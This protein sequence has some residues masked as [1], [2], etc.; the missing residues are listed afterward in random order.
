MP[1]STS[2]Q[3]SQFVTSRVTR[4]QTGYLERTSGA[5]GDLAALRQSGFRSPG[6]DPRVWNLIFEDLPQALLGKGSEARAPA[7]S[8]RL[9]LARGF[10]GFAGVS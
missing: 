9:G 6:D 2:S 5:I 7:K 4:L 1:P 10:V 8:L 3:V